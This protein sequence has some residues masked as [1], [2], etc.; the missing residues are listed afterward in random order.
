MDFPSPPGV[1]L[2]ASSFLYLLVHHP[3]VP[4]TAY[5]PF[6]VKGMEQWP[7]PWKHWTHNMSHRSEAADLIQ[8]PPVPAG[9]QQLGLLTCGM[10]CKFKISGSPSH[11]LNAE[12][13]GPSSGN[14]GG[15]SMIP[16]NPEEFLLSLSRLCVQWAWR[17]HRCCSLKSEVES[18][19]HFELWI[20]LNSNVER[21]SSVPCRVMNL[22]KGG[23][24]GKP[25]LES[26]GLTALLR[27]PMSNSD[28]GK[29][30]PNKPKTNTNLNSI[31]VKTE[32]THTHII[33]T[34]IHTHTL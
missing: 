2:P 6:M 14:E 7:C 27:S 24:A 20:L 9:R 15:S 28:C 29:W 19:G 25:R 16:N 33:K 1:L 4:H 3:A 18:S 11:S 10:Q 31:G 17:E 22:E 23:W 30:Q 12:A 8:K 32:N 26:G 13:Q 21:G 5:F 34:Q